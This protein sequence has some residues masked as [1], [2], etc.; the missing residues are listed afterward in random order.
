M[1]Q[2]Y[3]NVSCTFCHF[4]SLLL[5]LSLSLWGRLNTL[6]VYRC[7]L[8]FLSR[9][10]SSTKAFILRV[11]V[12]PGIIWFS[13][14]DPLAH[15]EKSVIRGFDYRNPLLATLFFTLVNVCPKFSKLCDCT[16]ACG[17]GGEG[18]TKLETVIRR[19]AW[20]WKWW[21]L[22]RDGVKSGVMIF[23]KMLWYKFCDFLG[24]LYMIFWKVYLGI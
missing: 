21:R 1:E 23:W 4:S 24:M 16:C 10:M 7:L 15:V 2:N 9:K 22:S 11:T 14:R 8:S 17:S 18:W 20:R 5:S 19:I 6:N 3:L 13:R 12:T